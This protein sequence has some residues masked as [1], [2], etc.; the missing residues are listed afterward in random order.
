MLCGDTSSDHVN[1]SN[2]AID[3]EDDTLE[4]VRD[5]VRD[6]APRAQQVA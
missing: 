5:L 6:L 2:L 4:H 3:V 1:A